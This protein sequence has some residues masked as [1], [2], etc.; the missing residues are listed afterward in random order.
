[1]KSF[2]ILGAIFF[3]ISFNSYG[4]GSLAVDP[5]TMAAGFVWS[6]TDK[7]SADFRAIEGCGNKNCKVV[8]NFQNACISFARSLSGK[9]GYGWGKGINEREAQSYAMASCGKYG[10]NCQVVDTH[11]DS[12]NMVQT[13][14]VTKNE[15]GC[16]Q[17]ET[18]RQE[19][20]TSGNYG[21]CLLVRLDWL[22][23]QLYEKKGVRPSSPEN[24]TQGIENYY[25]SKCKFLR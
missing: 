25:A 22:W 24:A 6:Y 1:M 16:R 8:A 20:A 23:D 19:C 10:S 12:V 21:Q 4:I 7:E 13:Q 14:K 11:C 9:R 15:D 2:F 5:N 17:I 18:A 3:S